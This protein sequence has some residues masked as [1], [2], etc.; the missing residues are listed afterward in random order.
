MFTI[1]SAHD[2]TSHTNGAAIR[3]DFRCDVRYE[4]VQGS[5]LCLS[6]NSFGFYF[7][8]FKRQIL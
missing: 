5:V 8:A 6:I 7:T 1:Q 3:D 2:D 4:Y